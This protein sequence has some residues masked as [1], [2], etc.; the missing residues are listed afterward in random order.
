MLVGQPQLALAED[1]PG[2]LNAADHCGLQHR[3]LPLCPSSTRAPTRRESDLLSG[4]D[5]RRAAHDAVP[6]VVADVDGGEAQA[7]GVRMRLHRRDLPD[8]DVVAPVAAGAHDAVDGE[9][10]HRQA[11]RPVLPAAGAGQRTRSTT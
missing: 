11:L 10:G 2:R 8:A 5:V 7:V 9:A 3:G 4:G 6:L 1:H